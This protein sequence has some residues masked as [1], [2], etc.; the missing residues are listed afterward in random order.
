MGL[1]LCPSRADSD[2]RP[3]SS[4][5]WQLCLFQFFDLK[6]KKERSKVLLSWCAFHWSNWNAFLAWKSFLLPNFHSLCD[7]LLSSGSKG[8]HQWGERR[9]REG[10]SISLS[11]AQKAPQ[12]MLECWR[13]HNIFQMFDLQSPEGVVVF[14]GLLPVPKRL[15]RVPLWTFAVQKS[16]S[17]AKVTQ[18]SHSN[19]Q[20][21]FFLVHL[22]LILLFC[23]RLFCDV[24]QWQEQLDLS[25]PV[26]YLV[27]GWDLLADT[28][29]SNWENLGSAISRQSRAWANTRLPTGW[30]RK[31]VKILSAVQRCTLHW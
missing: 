9:E 8:T 15:L 7:W 10:I 27:W 6:E 5:D 4:K 29:P 21:N 24:L 17:F 14:S 23:R 12:S 3:E 28:T 11:Q 30:V 18:T 19:Q 22:T 2:Q 13:W 16:V 26:G 31:E 25:N 1:H 20:A